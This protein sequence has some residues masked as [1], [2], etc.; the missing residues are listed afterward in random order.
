[1]GVLITANGYDVATS[2]NVDTILQDV[3]E[4]ET[5]LHSYEKWLCA[6][7]SPNGEIHVADEIS[8]TSFTAFRVDAGNNTWGSWVQILGSAD[9]PI[10]AGKTFFD[11]HELFFL[12]TERDDITIFQLAFGESA[13]AALIARTY[14]TSPFKAQTN[15][16]DSGPIYIQNKRQPAGVKAWA[17]CFIP[18]QNTG[19]M[20]FYI[21]LHEYAA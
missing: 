7:A 18:G 21:G 4:I 6:A 15:L 11:L 19:T 2:Q 9:T 16:I 8:A 14:T 12:Q 1:M 20:D 5:H 17:R 13:A 3:T 10:E